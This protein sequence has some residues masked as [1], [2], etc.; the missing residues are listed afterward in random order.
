MCGDHHTGRIDPR[1]PMW[2]CGR[3]ELGPG[4]RGG[5]QTRSS[6][7]AA[8]VA[9]AS[10]CLGARMRHVLV[11]LSIEELREARGCGRRLPIGKA[12]R[13]RSPHDMASCGGGPT[14]AKTI[15]PSAVQRAADLAE[16]GGV[17]DH[18]SSRPGRS[19]LRG[20]HTVATLARRRAIVCTGAL[21]ADEPGAASG[22][23]PGGLRAPIRGK[24]DPGAFQTRDHAHRGDPGAT[25]QGNSFRV[26]RRDANDPSCGWCQRTA[27][28][29]ASPALRRPTV[30]SEVTLR[31]WAAPVTRVEKA[32]STTLP[33][34]VHYGTDN[35]LFGVFPISKLERARAAPATRAGRRGSSTAPQRAG[36][37]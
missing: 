35:G 18:R 9:T 32:G 16:Q 13:G 27:A 36:R 8:R 2:R 26:A 34:A 6:A 30:W 15:V 10:G 1:R 3:G 19:H 20:H 5:P 33:A 29:G 21:G 17:V 4:A 22:S 25:L 11:G 31:T 37:R 12:G 7:V 14:G 24:R 28:Q 23:S